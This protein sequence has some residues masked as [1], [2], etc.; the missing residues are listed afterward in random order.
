MP[1]PRIIAQLTRPAR[2]SGPARAAQEGLSLGGGRR[3][4]DVAVS[5][6][7][8]CRTSSG[9]ASPAPSSSRRSTSRSPPCTRRV[10]VLRSG[11]L[12]ISRAPSP[13]LLFLLPLS[14]GAQR[15][16]S[17]NPPY[18]L[19]HPLSHSTSPLVLPFSSPSPSA[20]FPLSSSS[21][22]RKLN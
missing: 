18:S 20:L 13:S 14:S 5:R 19:P 21:Q 3:S 22:A 2:E 16:R 12:E 10:D 1:S 15:L 8:C 17:G 11:A 6:R 4:T 9:A 7:P